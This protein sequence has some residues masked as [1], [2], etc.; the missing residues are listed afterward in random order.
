M[1]KKIRVQEKRG[2]R[3]NQKLT[4]N[5]LL[6]FRWLSLILKYKKQPALRYFVQRFGKFL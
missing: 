4:E 1:T 3:I 2:L 5:N 6:N